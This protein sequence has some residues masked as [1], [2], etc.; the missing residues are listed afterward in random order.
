LLKDLNLVTGISIL[1]I[2]KKKQL[3]VHLIG[4]ENILMY[5]VNTVKLV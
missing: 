3:R 1:N 2:W 5:M 4:I